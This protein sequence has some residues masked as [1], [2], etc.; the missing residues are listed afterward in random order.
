M[1][2]ALGLVVLYESS[3]E[4]QSWLEYKYVQ[5]K[6]NIPHWWEYSRWWLRREMRRTR[7][8]RGLSGR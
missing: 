8:R 7:A 1:A 4:F 2:V 5:L 6:A 3:P